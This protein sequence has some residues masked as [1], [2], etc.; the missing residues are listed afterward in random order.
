MV[1]VCLGKRYT[2]KCCAFGRFFTLSILL[3]ID[4]LR[5]FTYSGFS[6]FLVEN[7]TAKPLLNLVCEPLTEIAED[8]AGR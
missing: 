5:Q 6:E 1:T 2:D 3:N 4:S 8:R 7:V